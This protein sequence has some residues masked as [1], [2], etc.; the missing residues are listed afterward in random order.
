MKESKHSFL[1]TMRPTLDAASSSS[2]ELPSSASLHEGAVSE[3]EGLGLEYGVKLAGEQEEDAEGWVQ[4]YCL[5]ELGAGV[6]QGEMLHEKISENGK[7]VQD[8]E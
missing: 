6:P 5:N 4:L 2:S 3:L 1:K 7:H 8:E